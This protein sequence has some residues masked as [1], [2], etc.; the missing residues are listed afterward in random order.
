MLIILCKISSLRKA[1]RFSAAELLFFPTFEKTFEWQGFPSQRGYM[2]HY[3]W[4]FFSIWW[5]FLPFFSVDLP[6]LNRFGGHPQFS[7]SRDG[8]YAAC[9][10]F[11]LRPAVKVAFF[12]FPFIFVVVVPKV[13][14]RK[15]WLYISDTYLD[16]QMWYKNCGFLCDLL[17][18]DFVFY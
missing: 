15:S 4:L 3:V 10:I 18:D 16:I 13:A 11:R 8:H 14:D 6:L 2:H 5:Y 17:S 9:N 1:A 7:P 12:L